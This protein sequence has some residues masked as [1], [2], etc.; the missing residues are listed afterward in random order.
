LSA[1]LAGTALVGNRQRLG[2]DSAGLNLWKKWLKNAL[3]F[4]PGS[5]RKYNQ[6]TE[7]V[8]VLE[9][10]ANIPDKSKQNKDLFHLVSLAKARVGR[11]K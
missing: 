5:G 7:F 10:A 6:L 2:A 11:V 8:A 1:E 4:A 9:R 3:V